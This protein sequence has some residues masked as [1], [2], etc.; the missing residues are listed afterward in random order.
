MENRW[1]FPFELEEQIGAGA[2]GLVY[3]ARFVKNDRRVA[4]KLLPREV[5]ANPTLAARFQR[6]METLKD[7]RHPNIVHC[8]GGTCKGDQWFYAMELVNGGTVEKLIAEQG[9]L[10]WRQ[11]VDFCRQ[12]CAALAHAHK[13]G[14]VHR[15]FKPG[16]LLLT[17]EGNLKLSDFGIAQLTSESRLTAA[18]KT[19]G[20]LHYM[21]PEQISG[22]SETTAVSDLYSLGC[23][24]Y[25]MITGKPPFSGSTMGEI[26]QKH[27]RE[28]PPDPKAVALDCPDELRD[29]V[30]ELLAKRPADRPP[31]AAAVA[32][33]L[34]D[35]VEG[36]IVKSRRPEGTFSG[37]KEATRPEEDRA[38]TPRVASRFWPVACA[39]ALALGAVLGAAWNTGEGGASAAV[40][41]LGAGLAH[42][43]PQVRLFAAESLGQMG[44]AARSAVPALSQSLEDPD[45]GVRSA[46]AKALGQVGKRDP[47]LV[48]S[49]SRVAR[50]DDFEPVRAAAN[51]AVQELES[52]PGGFLWQAIS[53]VLLLL[54]G[55]GALL[56]WKRLA[57][58]TAGPNG[59]ARHGTAA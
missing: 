7:L 15:D 18:G 8:F 38:A 30:L 29:L 11:A 59:M 36:V 13:R 55:G 37:K 57:P 33:R 42:P 43:A 4:L 20:S 41:R 27:L 22:K 40:A 48:G 39:L 2:M 52:N 58:R 51:H 1:I 53:L 35:L 46:A 24:L 19:V 16:N 9:R 3:R 14:I 54:L 5:A 25:E 32:E 44:A 31:S 17:R 49:L 45:P 23:T 26:L 56:L 34:T 10:H 28:A 6:E 47:A 21:S 50:T 12:A